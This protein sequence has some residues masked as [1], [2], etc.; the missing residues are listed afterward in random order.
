MRV[1]RKVGQW[2]RAL[3]KKAGRP[4]NN[5]S[6]RRDELN[7]KEAQAKE[8]GYTKNELNR[9]EQLATISAEEFEKYVSEEAIKNEAFHISAPPKGGVGSALCVL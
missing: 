5:S 2:G 1:Q 8:A 4:E 9:R 3:E 7:T 6:P